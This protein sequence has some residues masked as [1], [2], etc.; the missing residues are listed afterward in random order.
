MISNILCETW[1]TS[2][3]TSTLCLSG[4]HFYERRGSVRI[5]PDCTHA[6]SQ[7]SSRGRNL[8]PLNPRMQK[9]QNQE[10]SQQRPLCAQS[11]SHK[12]CFAQDPHFIYVGSLLVLELVKMQTP[13]H[14]LKVKGLA[15]QSGLSL[16]TNSL[17]CLLSVPLRRCLSRNWG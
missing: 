8:Y 12:V 15:G 3:F 14:A 17:I 1:R 13:L 10:Q 4:Y 9:S 11:Q 5:I 16:Y 6:N 2:W 7:L